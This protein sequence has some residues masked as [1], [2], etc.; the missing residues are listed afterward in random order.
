M[1]SKT[2]STIE[3]NATWG[4]LS[5]LVKYQ[6]VKVSPGG[7]LHICKY[8]IILRHVFL[9]NIGD[10]ARNCAKMHRVIYN[11]IVYSQQRAQGLLPWL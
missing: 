10:Y 9:H 11:T 4:R 3:A 5:Y 7:L 2:A 1:K 8:F 6:V